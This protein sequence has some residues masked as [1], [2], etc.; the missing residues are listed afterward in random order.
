[1]SVGGSG[2]RRLRGART[3]AL[4]FLMSALPSCIIFGS[5]G[6]STVGQGKQYV[7]GNAV[8]DQFFAQLFQVQLEMAKAP[9]DEQRIVH[10]LA[11]KLGLDDQAGAA[12][13]LDK[14][15]DE[16]H[17]LAHHNVGL[18]LVVAQGSVA[19]DA[20]VSLHVTGTASG[21][22]ERELIKPVRKAADDTL[23]LI[24]RMHKARRTLDELRAMDSSL[25]S[26]V[27]EAFR[28][29]GPAK[30]AEVEKNL[31]DAGILI[32]LMSGRA[33]DV[34]DAARHFLGGLSQA[35]TTRHAPVSAPVEP[36]A[37]KKK[38]KKK[39][40]WHGT[41]HRPAHHAEH[42]AAPH[43]PPPPKKSAAPEFEP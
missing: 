32:P 23:Q 26:D 42:K 27:S 4:L 10:G 33:G 22:D 29:G 9:G 24:E 14:V 39:P 2:A 37:A 18:R 5:P 38:K 35:A 6:P 40:R 7:S 31:H 17:Q 12:A 3:A 16:A 28:L 41:W 19:T 36:P 15:K 20:S 21:E 30:R 1:M 8:F 34:A 25:E 11:Q 13:V 43:A